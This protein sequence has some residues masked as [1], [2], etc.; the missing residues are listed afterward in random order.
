MAK[1]GSDGD[2]NTRA[3][4]PVGSQHPE[5]Q[6]ADVHRAALAAAV[7]GGSSEE[8]GVGTLEVAALADEVAVTPVGGRHLVGIGE[9]G[10]NSCR[11]RFLTDVQMQEPGQLARL[12]EA[13]TV[14]LELPD[15]NHA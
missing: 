9:V 15:P 10:A 5:V 6:V 12:G 8:F 3:H 7:A 13:A 1:A 11:H 2:G 14:L 4:D